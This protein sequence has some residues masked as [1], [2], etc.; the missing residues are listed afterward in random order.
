MVDPAIG[1]GKYGN[2]FSHQI[3][4]IANLMAHQAD[5]EFHRAL[6]EHSS[7][8]ILLT[9]PDGQI[10]EANPAACRMLGRSVEEIR[11]AGRSGV[12]DASD[13]RLA[14]ALSERAAQGYSTAE[15]VF[16]RGDGTRFPAEVTS[17]VFIDGQGN[18]RTSMFMRDITLRRALETEREQY[19]RF[20]MLSG[21]ALCIADP[22]GCFVRV[23][24][25]MTHLTGY[26][27]T[28]LLSKP[29]LDF[30]IPEDRERTAGEMKQQVAARPSLH[31][32][33]RYRCNN[34]EIVRLSW[35]A[36]FDKR[37]GLTYAAARD[38]TQQTE[39]ETTLRRNYELLDRIFATTHFSLAYLDRNFNFLRVNKAYA[40]ACGR[41]TDFF[42]GKNHFALY[43]NEENE[44]IFRQTVGSG[45]PFTIYAKPFQFPDHPEWGITY[46]DWTLHP[47]KNELGHVEGLLFV[48]LDVT[49]HM[50]AEEKLRTNEAS[51]RVALKGVDMA[52]FRQDQDLRY[53]WTYS[54]QLGYTSNEVIGKAD[55]DLLPPESASQIIE[56]KRRVLET[57]VSVRAEVQIAEPNQTRFFDLIVEP[58]MDRK[59]KIVGVTGALLDITE[60]K[61]AEHERA[62]LAAIVESSNDAIL[63]RGLD[64]SILAWNAAAERLFGWSAQ[65]AIGQSIDLIV[66]SERAGTLRRFIESAAR[67][68]APGPVETTHMRKDG[69]RIPT[70]V[71]FS[72]VKDAVGRVIAHSYT[73]RDMSELKHK[74]EA[75]RQLSHRLRSV[76]E[77]ERR[78]IARELHD[79]IGQDLSTLGLLLASL[80]ARLPHASRDATKRPLQDIQGLLKSMVA[81]VR[82]VM[83]ELRPLVLDDYGLLAA[84][85]QLATVFAQRTGITAELGGVE[86]RPRL[87]SVIETTMFRIS[88]EALNNVAKHA[89]AKQVVISLHAA[90]NRIV[91][92]IADDGIGF[93]ASQ[94]PPDQRH[95]GLCTMRERAEEAGIAF[96]L[97]ST[98]GAGTR[99][100]LE[101][102]RAT[103]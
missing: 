46:W 70:Q 85:Q 54:P 44:A 72:P 9:A 71:T 37:D 20:F 52:L 2:V 56:L 62:Q 5:T 69:A 40:D 87:P 55:S 11:L 88:Q 100:V 6:F 74:E 3:N 94:T 10:F 39:A 99:V 31:F 90:A 25:A 1:R 29:F 48:L 47:L 97:E 79:R 35:N 19:F 81:N 50:R 43:P 4:A 30:V 23:N 14:A 17:A 68:E 101:V 98:P 89:Q 22:F 78:A 49:Q 92:E 103:T 21:D 34:G 7:D 13:P 60:R 91:L 51:L 80:G 26:S 8:G 95:W 86:L 32:V 83:A 42:P 77:A 66:P 28:E 57:G 93:D 82:D 16:V 65:E 76:E 63:M 58:L 18:S 102:E 61:R 15:L 24:P 67:D 84:L 96:V 45:Q 73:V 64:R 12:I 27:E 53:T 38:I 36:Y 75:L 41:M 59:E 33:N